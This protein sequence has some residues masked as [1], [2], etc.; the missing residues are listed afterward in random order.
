MSLIAP[1]YFVLGRTAIDN[2]WK[3]RPANQFDSL[4]SLHPAFAALVDALQC[5]EAPRRDVQGTLVREAAPCDD[6]Y[7]GVYSTVRFEW[8]DAK[9][10]ANLRDRGSKSRIGGRNTASAASSQSASLM[11]FI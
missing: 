2:G 3:T 5:A 6:V 8:D 1:G 7:T 9:S 4:A 11:V 10:D